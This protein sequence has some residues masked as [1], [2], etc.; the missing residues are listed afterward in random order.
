[1]HI[2]VQTLRA[3]GRLAEPGP[4]RSGGGRGAFATGFLCNALNPKTMLFVVS[5]FTQ[6]ADPSLPRRVAWGF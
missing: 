4:A 2:G 5:V 3:G 6:V 1:M